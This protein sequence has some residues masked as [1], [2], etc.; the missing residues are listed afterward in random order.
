MD[1]IEIHNWQEVV[2]IKFSSFN[3]FDD[4]IGLCV[5]TFKLLP[6]SFLFCF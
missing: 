3:H 5:G 4:L 6:G 1:V 2:Q